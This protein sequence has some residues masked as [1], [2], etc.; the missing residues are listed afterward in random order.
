MTVR[1]EQTK[2]LARHILEHEGE[3]H[4]SQGPKYKPDEWYGCDMVYGDSYGYS[5]GIVP[6]TLETVCLGRTE[7]VKETLAS[8]VIPANQC[9]DAR[10]ALEDI[11]ATIE[12]IKKEEHGTAKSTTGRTHL[13]RG[14]TSRV[15]R[16]KQKATRKT[17]T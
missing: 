6:E 12:T 13:Q 9:P 14:R 3:K 4:V 15:A 7:K 10:L 16:Y 8:G 5:W 11:L 17:K 1:Q 2:E